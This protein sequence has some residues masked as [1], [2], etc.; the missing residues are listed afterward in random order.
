MTRYWAHLLCLQVLTFRIVHLR[1]IHTPTTAL[2]NP[3]TTIEPEVSIDPFAEY[4]TLGHFDDDVIS[5]SH[6]PS[7]SDVL[8]IL[9]DP[10]FSTT[11]SPDCVPG[12]SFIP[13]T[14]SESARTGH[15]EGLDRIR[16][17]SELTTLSLGTADV[18]SGS[19]TAN[20]SP[21]HLAISLHGIP[22]HHFSDEHDSGF[23]LYRTADSPRLDRIAEPSH[24]LHAVFVDMIRR[25]AQDRLQLTTTV[26]IIENLT[27]RY[28]IWYAAQQRG[29]VLAYAYLDGTSQPAGALRY[30]LAFHPRLSF[31]DN[32][33]LAVI[34][35][36]HQGNTLHRAYPDTVY[37]WVILVLILGVYQPLTG[38]PADVAYAAV[39]VRTPQYVEQIL[40]A[41][42]QAIMSSGL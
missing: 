30:E 25:R 42:R 40:A 20:N 2:V 35:I 41:R 11:G 16:E 5:N 28:Q 38:I 22:T 31:A 13:V 36:S 32:L 1:P 14:G 7:W 34:Y 4:T 29:L 33:R 27:Q 39:G 21:L 18:S 12:P 24:E 8:A 3:N 37:T 19:I 9:C 23:G 6:S 10:A 17:S 15:Q 26:T